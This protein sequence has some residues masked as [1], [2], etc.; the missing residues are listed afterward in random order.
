VSCVPFE[1]NGKKDLYIQ[2][3][4]SIVRVFRVF[5]SD[6]VAVRS[7]FHY[8]TIILK[9]SFDAGAFEGSVLTRHVD[10]NATAGKSSRL[11]LMTF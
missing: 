4:R 9:A 1:A 6:E 5:V 7:G 8:K 3:R 10:K 11:I 2:H